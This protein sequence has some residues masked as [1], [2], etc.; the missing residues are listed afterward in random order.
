MK[1][2]ID[3]Y[4]VIGLLDHPRFGDGLYILNVLFFPD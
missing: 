2:L 4:Q 1:A 3:I